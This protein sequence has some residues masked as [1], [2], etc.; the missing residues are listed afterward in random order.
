MPSPISNLSMYIDHYLPSANINFVYMTESSTLLKTSALVLSN[1]HFVTKS[2]EGNFSA[3]DFFIYI[4]EISTIKYLIVSASANVDSPIVVRRLKKLKLNE[5]SNGLVANHGDHLTFG[6]E[7]EHAPRL[8]I[9]THRTLYTLNE[10]AKSSRDI[11]YKKAHEAC[12]IAYDP[13]INKRYQTFLNTP[14]LY[15]QLYTI[16]TR[17]TSEED[18]LI[19]H[20][21]LQIMDGK[22][23]EKLKLPS[24]TGGLPPHVSYKEIHFM[25][26]V[27]HTFIREAFISNNYDV[28]LTMFF[29]PN[30]NNI[31]CFFDIGKEINKRVVFD[32]YAPLALKACYASLN[33]NS[34]EVI[35]LDKFMTHVQSTLTILR[36]FM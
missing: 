17:Y 32:I 28:V 12:T 15:S 16:N 7:N 9:N 26:D 6:L 1:K 5:E 20:H 24:K 13:I 34:P 31:V 22:P 27:F 4:Y 29:K 35:H 23:V 25:S 10:S 30:Y 33:K 18:K 19:I 3:G 11:F 14:C 21:L 2:Y 8:F 36:E